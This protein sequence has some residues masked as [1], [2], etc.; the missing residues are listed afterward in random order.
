MSETTSPAVLLRARIG[1]YRDARRKRRTI[2]STISVWVE[3]FDEVTDALLPVDGTLAALYWLPALADYDSPAQSVEPVQTAPGQW[4]VDVPGEMVGTYTVQASLLLDDVTAEAVEI[5][6]DIDSLGGIAVT[7]TGEIPWAAVSAAGAAAGAS[8]GI[9]AGR[10]AGAV[11]GAEAGA[12][13]GASAGAASAAE[14][15]V[16]A[17]APAVEQVT[18]AA[19]TVATQAGQVAGD[20]TLAQ[21]AA[22][23]AVASAAPLANAVAVV[24]GIDARVQPIEA[25]QPPQVNAGRTVLYRDAV[26]GYSFVAMDLDGRAALAVTTDR[27]MDLNALRLM[28]GQPYRD[29][30]PEDFAFADL[31]GRAPLYPDKDGWLHLAVKE[32]LTPVT[33]APYRD[34][35]IGIPV[36]YDL[37]G[38]VA[39]AVGQDGT[40]TLRLSDDVVDD[41]AGR[42]PPAEASA[43]LRGSWIAAN[44][45]RAGL[46]A[47]EVTD[48]EGLTWPV[49]QRTDS[50]LPTALLDDQRPVNTFHCY[51]QSNAGRPDSDT[52]AGI[53]TALFP[54]HVVTFNGF[55]GDWVGDTLHDPATLT[56]LMPLKDRS[57]YYPSLMTLATFAMERL[58][59]DQGIKGPGRFSFTDWYGGQP[60]TTFLPG[61]T[62]WNNLLASAK[63]APEVI[64]RYGRTSRARAIV[65]YQGESGPA[66]GYEALLDQV[67]AAIGPA[68]Q[69]AARQVETPDLVIIQTNSTDSEIRPRAVPQA[70]YDFAREHHGNGATMAGPAYQA[71]KY[72][73]NHS[74]Q[75]GR[76]MVAEQLAVALREIET[77]RGWAPIWPT[78][79]TRI[80]AVITAAF[81]VPFGLSLAWDTDWIKPATNYGFVFEDDSGATPAI[82][83]VTL[84]SANTVQITLAAT[85]TGGAQTLVYA[86][87]QDAIDDGWSSSRGQL[88]AATVFD[89]PFQ[90]MGF[91]IPNKVRLYAVAFQEPVA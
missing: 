41:L 79:V 72:D 87:G 81:N 13:A 27:Q 4:R 80:G 71:P 61:T 9:A 62:T 8:A 12:A 42:L 3:A 19:A 66:D 56:D 49:V 15:A 25:A 53:S 77:G 22:E 47:A 60:L 33:P 14:I 35:S 44:V 59:R 30:Y 51:G 75:L 39:I 90:R 46:V 68:V 45:R 65:F 89:S 6:F 32:S 40:T 86:M 23:T 57:N 2:G 16:E 20:T 63:A 17:V 70:H 69:T 10:S 64:G 43:T 91:A 38:R 21:E 76:M 52:F 34:W 18:T 50:T 1:A 11:S 82:S 7:S 55:M 26:D 84:A 85:P 37:D 24:E 28:R 31:D 74:T 78:S 54:H 83:A 88:M 58:D 73:E 5:Q 67:G 36:A 48:D 29:A